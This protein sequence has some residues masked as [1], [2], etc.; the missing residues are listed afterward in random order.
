LTVIFL[1]SLFSFFSNRELLLEVNFITFDFT[2][3]ICGHFSILSTVAC[4]IGQSFTFTGKGNQKEL[5]IFDHLLWECSNGMSTQQC[6]RQCH[7]YSKDPNIQVSSCICAIYTT[8]FDFFLWDYLVN[9]FTE[10]LV[11]WLHFANESTLN[12]WQK[13]AIFVT[14]ASVMPV[15]SKSN[16]MRWSHFVVAIPITP[17]SVISLLFAIHRCWKNYKFFLSYLFCLKWPL[18]IG[19]YGKCFIIDGSIAKI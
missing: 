5:L 2:F 11:I 8:K 15:F 3:W 4:V 9:S 7:D 17:A 13:L 18:A 10:S 16:N 14:E 1:V 6:H 19:Y 12:L